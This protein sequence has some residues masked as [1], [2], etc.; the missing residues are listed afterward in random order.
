MNYL[1]TS[2]SLKDSV[3]HLKKRQGEVI[4]FVLSV[5]RY[6]SFSLSRLQD[7]FLSFFKFDLPAKKYKKTLCK[8]PFYVLLYINIT[9]SITLFIY[10]DI[11]THVF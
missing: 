6:Q 9:Q 8:L 1:S 11:F 5:G 2:E 10:V 3:L 4:S 7:Y